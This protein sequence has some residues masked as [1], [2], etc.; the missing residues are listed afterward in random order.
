MITIIAAIGRNNEL[1]KNNDLIWNLPSDLRF[2]KEQTL[3]A[4][5]A[6]GKN[7]LE[8]LPKL[9]P[10]RKHI[11]LS[12]DNDFNKDVTDVLVYN[13]KDEFINYC[14]SCKDNIYIIG[15]ASIYAMFIDLAD[16]IILTEI[17]AEDKEAQVYFPKFDK[18]KYTYEYLS[19]N[20]DNGINFKHVKY[21]KKY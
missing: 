8:S 13:N 17:D 1:G 2:F 6:M 3:G 7:T 19:S 21:I 14:K 5:I 9:L 18:S 10:G 4:K 16:V 12:L 20:I 15:G 11:V